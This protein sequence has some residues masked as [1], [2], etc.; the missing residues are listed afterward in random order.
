MIAYDYPLLGFFWTM[1]MLFLWL[2]WIILLV[3]VFADIFRN[4]RMGGWAKA[5]WSIFVIVLPF[6]GVLVYLIAHGGDMTARD[7]E[8]ARAEKEA[9]DPTCARRPDPPA[10]RP[11]TSSPSS[12]ASATT[13]S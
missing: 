7:T 6:L 1:L 4:D 10:R 8:Q 5:L 12:P 13:A 3:R 9:F 11:P 2:A